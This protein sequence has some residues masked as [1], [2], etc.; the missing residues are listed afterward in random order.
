MWLSRDFLWFLKLIYDESVKRGQKADWDDPEWSMLD[1]G[2]YGSGARFLLGNAVERNN[3]ESAGWML[4]HGANPN[5]AP[6]R[7]RRMSK[8]T[9]YEEAVGNGFSEMAESRAPWSTRSE[10]TSREARLFAACFRLDI[11]S[12]HPVCRQSESLKS[13]ETISPM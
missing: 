1:M 8:R 4:A 3:L 9:L 7:D 5:A 6:P 13:I 11:S 10:I 12:A 2:G